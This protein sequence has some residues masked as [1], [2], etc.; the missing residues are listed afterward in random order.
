VCAV[1]EGY[2]TIVVKDAH[3]AQAFADSTAAQVSD[4]FDAAWERAAA[5]L[6]GAKDVSF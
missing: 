1:C 3:G 4:H 5:R 6:M 2:D